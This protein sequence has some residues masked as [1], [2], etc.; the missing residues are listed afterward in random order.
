MVVVLRCKD[1]CPAI[2][3]GDYI[4]AEGEKEH[5]Q[6]FYAESVSIAKH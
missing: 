4:T 3:V 5:E 6:L 1:Q 2:K